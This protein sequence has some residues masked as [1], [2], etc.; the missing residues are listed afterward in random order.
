MCILIVCLKNNK[1][2]SRA[3]RYPSGPKVQLLMLCI[4]HGE[5]LGLPQ[6]A[7]SLGLGGMANGRNGQCLIIIKL[8]YYHYVFC[9]RTN[10]HYPLRLH[11]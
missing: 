10:Y 7:V 9:S 8:P 6:L 2:H 11:L 5:A 3:T 4:V 1:S